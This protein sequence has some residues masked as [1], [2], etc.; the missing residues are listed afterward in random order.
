MTSID[1]RATNGAMNEML[2][3]AKELF[4]RGEHIGILVP[5]KPSLDCLIASEVLVRA[6]VAKEKWVGFLRA[7]RWDA[8]SLWDHLPHVAHSSPLPK[9]F[10]ISVDTSQ[11]P[12]SQLRYEKEENKIDVILSPKSSPLREGFVSFREGKLLCDNLIT[13]GIA[14]IEEENVGM[15]IPPEFFTD[16]P[17]LN[18]DCRDLNRHY[19]EVNLVDSSQGSISELI[20][21]LFSESNNSGVFGADEA[22]L[23][24]AGILA[25]TN[26]LASAA[27]DAHTFAIT[28]DL[29]GR[30]GNYSKARKIVQLSTPIPLLQLLGRASIRSRGDSSRGI[31][32][33]F[34]TAEDFQKTG[35][36]SDDILRALTHIESLFPPHRAV[37]LL[38]QDQEEGGVRAALAAPRPLLEALQARE[39]GELQNPHLTLLAAFS[40]FKEAEDR[41]TSLLGET[42]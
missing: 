11:T 37:V 21:E 42:L 30:G 1:C 40:S 23:L 9:E 38:W 25:S 20:Y 29:I 18:I 36:G 3:K 12:I 2:T 34:L 6:L 35:R 14:D 5:E 16:T 41:L 39:P 13:L 8:I 22:T 32:W 7:P 26:G 33:S 31:L 28:A 10:I 15:D 24:L 4:D 17:I 19:G 27:T